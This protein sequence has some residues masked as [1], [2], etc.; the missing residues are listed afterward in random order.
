M[1]AWLT[2]IALQMP[3]KMEP[4]GTSAE[5]DFV[6]REPARQHAAEADADRESGDHKADFQIVQR[7]STSLP[8]SKR[9]D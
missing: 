8:N 9:S 5:L 3:M 2:E 4:S 6:A 1:R 7:A